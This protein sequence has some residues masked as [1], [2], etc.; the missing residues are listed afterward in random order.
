MTNTIR[1]TLLADENAERR[2]FPAR[3]DG[4]LVVAFRSMREIGISLPRPADRLPEQDAEQA[5]SAFARQSEKEGSRVMVGC[6]AT[7][8]ALSL[9]GGI[10]INPS[11]QYVLLAIQQIPG[12][13]K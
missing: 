12:F 13:V 5:H 11:S 2:V 4:W 3:D 7:L 1:N 6:V 9:L 10:I 8:A